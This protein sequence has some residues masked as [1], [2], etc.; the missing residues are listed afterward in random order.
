[1]NYLL[2]REI[3]FS[4]AGKTYSKNY[5]TKETMPISDYEALEELV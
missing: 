1:M 3:G 2:R 5:L 4:Y